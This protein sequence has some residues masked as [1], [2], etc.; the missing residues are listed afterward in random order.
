MRS[1]IWGPWRAL[2]TMKKTSRMTK[3]TTCKLRKLMEKFSQVN[4]N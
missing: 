1:L 2:I 3:V 4:N